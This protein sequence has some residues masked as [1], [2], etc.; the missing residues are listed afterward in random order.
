MKKKICVVTATRAEYGLLS[1]LLKEISKSET[2]LLQMI[3]TGMHLSPEFG[4]TYREIEN[5]GYKINDKVEALL[6]SDSAVGV[7]KS[8]GL[9]SI[10]FA[11]ALDKLRPDLIIILGDRFEMLA[12][13]QVALI[14]QIP[15]AHIAGGDVTE[16]AYD[17]AIRH[18]IS[19]MSN[20]HFVTNEI[21]K[22]RL[23]QLGE[24]PQ[25]VFNVG[26]LGIDNIK[27]TELLSLKELSKLMNFNFLKK[28]I[29]ITLHP[30]TVETSYTKKYAQIL[31]EALDEIKILFDIG[32]IFTKAN[33]DNGGREINYLFENYCKDNKNAKIYDSLGKI[34]YLSCLHYI[35]AV[36]GNSSSGLYEVPSFN[37]ATINIGNRQLGRLKASSVIDVD[38]EKNQIKNAII[39]ALNKN[40]ATENPY[41]EGETAY[42]IIDILNNVE[43][44]KT[45]RFF[46]I[47][48]IDS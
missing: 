2:F 17:D 15:I 19:K 35:D 40:I 1:G 11:E 13:A 25:T 47:E 28:N 48:G 46:D 44:K 18:S 14:L 22:K 21:A 45:K 6:S 33:A 12:V 10:G 39:K 27:N 32:F 26:S 24:D 20:L 37:K 23:I 16:G 36:V 34:K 9:T 31:L 42:K 5:D 29:L 3:V 43:W 41:G 4:F 38:F 8:M 30:V 7:A